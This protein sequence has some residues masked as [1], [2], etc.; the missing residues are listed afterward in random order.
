MAKKGESQ[1]KEVKDRIS[2]SLIGRS[3]WNKGLAWPDTQRKIISLG[4]K[5]TFQWIDDKK[6]RQLITRDY[7][8]AGDCLKYGLFK[9]TILLYGSVLEAS[10][11]YKL[12]VDANTNFSDLIKRA[13]EKG[14]IKDHLIT[15]LNLLR[16]FRNYV[17]LHKEL[18]QNFSLTEGLA[19]LSMEICDSIIEILK[20]SSLLT[21]KA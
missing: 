16:D 3:V 13:E 11:I 19:T 4:K 12:K 5:G 2:E 8:I 6:L 18:S 9:P 20:K 1:P 10:L 14:L 15:K 17:H 7:I 21:S